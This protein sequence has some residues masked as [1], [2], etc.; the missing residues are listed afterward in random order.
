M[1]SRTSGNDGAGYARLHAVADQWY[2][3]T[4]R[5]YGRRIRLSK[6]AWTHYVDEALEQWDGVTAREAGERTGIAPTVIS[7]WRRR[8]AKGEE[9]QEVRGRN[10]DALLR[11]LELGYATGRIPL[12]IP[13]R[14]RRP[15]RHPSQR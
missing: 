14:M 8:R 15:P 13:I 3:G 9:I 7:I 2:V 10:A 1:D 6:K 4:V 12:P 11:F 5:N